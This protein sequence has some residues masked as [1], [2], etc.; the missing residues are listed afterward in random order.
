M[1]LAE[2]TVVGMLTGFVGV[3]GG[4]LIVPALLILGKLPMR[5]AIGTS[6]VIIVMK[7]LIGFGKY[8]YYL[9]EHGLTVDWYTIG[10]FSLIGLVGAAA[11]QLLNTRLNQRALMQVFAVFLIFVGGYV[12]V[13]EGSKLLRTP[14]VEARPLGGPTI[15]TLGRNASD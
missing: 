10:I 5:K 1:V 2:G 15:P 11:G 6:L 13:N 8:Q 3:G 14:T 7:S 9:L 4:F 12:V